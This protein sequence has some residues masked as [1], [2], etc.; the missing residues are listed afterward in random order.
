MPDHMKVIFLVVEKSYYCFT[1]FI[2]ATLIN[3]SFNKLKVKIY[4]HSPIK[5][6]EGL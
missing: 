6:N 3:I 5:Y 2:T 1:D 4:E